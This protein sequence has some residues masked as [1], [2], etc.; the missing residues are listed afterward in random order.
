MITTTVFVLVSCPAYLHKAK[1]T[2]CDLRSAGQWHG[3]VV[4]INVGQA[5]I[6]PTFLDFYKIT[7]KQFP[8]ISEKRIL[9]GDVLNNNPFIDTIDGREISLPNQWEKLHVM[10]PYFKKWER[11]V[12]MDAGMRVLHNVHE[13]ILT[14][15]YKW[16]FLAPD[17]GGN[18][19]VL[20]NP[21]KLF[22][23]Q[24][25]RGDRK[26]MEALKTDFPKIKELKETY[27]L[28]CMWVY[29]TSILDVCNKEEMV[30]GM[31]KYPVCKTNE[32][33]LMNLFLHFKYGL[34]ERFPKY[35]PNGKI[36]FD[37]CES[38]NPEPSNWRDYCF[39][40]YPISIRF[41]DTT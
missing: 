40:K 16:K 26:T 11:V 32:M 35:A 8:E 20:P 21:N 6:N 29:D 38:N 3:D 23:S 1:R 25:S 15:D 39:L 9:V 28:N 19:S 18:F 7:E 36:L 30:E 34:W 12:F 5:V 41:E 24:I 14:L 2:I 10:D 13:S 22:E 33:A 31:L 27:F 37:W 17:D 4:L